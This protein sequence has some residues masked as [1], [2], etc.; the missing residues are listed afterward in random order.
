[1]GY[2]RF[3]KWIFTKLSAD[4]KGGP[5]YWH[6]AFLLQLIRHSS[7]EPLKRA[8]YDFIDAIANGRINDTIARAVHSGRGIDLNKNLDG[9][10]RPII[11]CSIESD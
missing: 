5:D 10:I 1:M 3:C 7:S 2:E 6:D 8:L 9:D 4:T 11:I